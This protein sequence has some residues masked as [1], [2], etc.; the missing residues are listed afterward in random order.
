MQGWCSLVPCEGHLLQKEAQDV[1][2][3]NRLSSGSEAEMAWLPWNL[4]RFP[5]WTKVGAVL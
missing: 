1:L 4:H 2:A 3:G 5:T